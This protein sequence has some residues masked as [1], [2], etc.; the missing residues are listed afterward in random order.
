[1]NIKIIMA[2]HKSKR[3]R[4]EKDEYKKITNEYDEVSNELSKSI[5]EQIELESKLT[6]IKVQIEVLHEQ[7]TKLR[8]KIIDEIEIQH[9]S[10]Q[11]CTCDV[12]LS[13]DHQY[14]KYVKCLKHLSRYFPNQGCYWCGYSDCSKYGC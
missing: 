9:F 7:Q 14:A 1:V 12:G 13:E 4:L 11:S 8:M 2:E 5:I 3:Q 6:K 10:N